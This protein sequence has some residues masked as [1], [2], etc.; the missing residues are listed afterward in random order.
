[1]SHSRRHRPLGCAL[2]AVA[3]ALCA[4]CTQSGTPHRSSSTGSSSARPIGSR[5][6]SGGPGTASVG[7][8]PDATAKAAALLAPAAPRPKGSVPALAA[9]LAKV[10]A[11]SGAPAQGRCGLPCSSA[12]SR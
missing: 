7:A 6:G 8:V 11:G 1:M 9:A 4:G 2:L 3:V 5:T 12:G 10:A